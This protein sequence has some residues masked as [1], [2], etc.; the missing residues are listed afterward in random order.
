MNSKQPASKNIFSAIGQP[1]IQ[2]RALRAMVSNLAIYLIIV[3][4]FE[5]F[6][7][8]LKKLNLTCFW[9]LTSL[10]ILLILGV[11]LYYFLRIYFPILKFLGAIQRL[12]NN[13]E[14]ENYYLEKKTLTP[15]ITS[16]SNIL[17]ELKNSMDREYQAKILIKQAEMEALQ[18]QINPHF[19]YNTLEAIRGQ[20]IVEDE[21]EIADMI[22]AL[23]AFF[24]YSISQRGSIVTLDEELNN[25]DNYF[26]IQQFRFGEKFKLTK[27]LDEDKDLFKYRLPKLTIQPI[28]ENAIFHGL[29]TKIGNGSITI[30]VTVTQNR[31]IINIVDDGIGIEKSKLDEINEKLGREIDYNADK[32]PSQPRGIALFN[33][34]QRI[35]L[36]FGESYGLF[37]YSSP[38]IGTNVE[39]S[40]PLI[41]EE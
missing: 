19:L 41:K 24:R 20:A 29:E 36:N 18:S 31:I 11:F 1:G 9:L 13:H 40:L 27:I 35:K 26:T 3:I 10:E 33:V 25:V 32:M 23:S 5:Y 22:E 16:I 6:L 39:I 21:V 28:V 30:R 17:I 7:F 2:T 15:D 8:N 38:D 37:V 4:I 12:E 34:N 14:V